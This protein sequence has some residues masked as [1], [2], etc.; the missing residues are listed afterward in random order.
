MTEELRQLLADLRGA[1]EL[2][3]SCVKEWTSLDARTRSAHQQ[4]MAAHKAV[5][6][7]RARIREKTGGKAA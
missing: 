5:E 4:C 7:I 3:E 2:Q 1:M 6:E